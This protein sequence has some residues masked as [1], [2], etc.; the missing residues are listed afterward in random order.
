M[1][2]DEITMPADFISAEIILKKSG[3]EKIK[4]GSFSDVYKHPAKSYVLKLFKNI[5]YGYIE[6]IGIVKNIKNKHFPRIIGN[7]V[8]INTVYSA[9]RIELLT[10]FDNNKFFYDMLDYYM[11]S[12]SSSR[13]S[14]KLR[15][16]QA[17]ENI[18][19]YPELKEACD[20]IA[21]L[22]KS[23]K[24]YSLDI[25]D[26]NIMMRGNDYVLIDPIETNM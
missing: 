22:I 20:I 14:F 1:R 3:Y 21:S 2:I 7:I 5:D 26:G 10:P 13:S 8:K 6:Y 25:H 24:K 4:S 23:N 12:L 17:K 11:R 9:I 15:K 16:K 18:K 19:Q